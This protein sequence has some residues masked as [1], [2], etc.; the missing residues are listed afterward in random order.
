[1]NTSPQKE[2]FESIHS[3]YTSHY[4]DSTSMRYRRL[5]IYNNLYK[6]IDFNNAKVAELAC[7][8]GFNSLELVREFPS[9]K[10][11]G[12]DISKKACEDYSSLVGSKSYIV[13][14]SQKHN[15][16]EE[17]DYVII[18]GGLHHCIGNLTNTF[19]NIY[20]MLK[21]GGELIMMEPNRNYFLDYFRR[22]WYRFD[23]Y[24]DCSTEGALD[25]DYLL[26]SQ[27][28]RFKSK[29]CLYY[30]GPA[31]FLI[32]NSLILRINLSLKK[33]IFKPLITLEKLYNS[34]G[35]KNLYPCFIAKWQK[36]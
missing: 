29:N 3:E 33:I 2:L 12:Y 25:H 11:V 18:I 16:S 14:I 24:F 28:K 19:N 34:I 20:S 15:F 23:K 26:K 8:G 7:G 21:P 32:Y 13:D 31:Y 4:F 36:L 35:I 22:I 6:G 30:G 27:S 17:F 9:I 5:F 1:M 10:I